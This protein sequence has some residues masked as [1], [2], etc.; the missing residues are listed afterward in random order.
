MMIIPTKKGGFMRLI[1]EDYVIEI[2]YDA[3]GASS[4]RE[5]KNLGTMICSDFGDEK[6]SR[7]FFLK[8]DFG[9]Y[10]DLDEIYD[11]MLD[12]LKKEY[13]AAVVLPIF[14]SKEENE[15]LFLSV[16]ES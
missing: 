3:A 5:R 16:S 15:Q 1:H 10:Y 2:E 8:H 9:D 4:P 12:V 6:E 7:D 13:D 14:Y 11:D